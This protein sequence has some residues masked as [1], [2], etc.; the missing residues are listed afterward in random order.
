MKRLVWSALFIALVAL[1]IPTPAFAQV[2]P[3]SSCSALGKTQTANGYKYTWIKAPR[4]FSNPLGKKLIWNKGVQLPK[5]KSLEEAQNTKDILTAL[6]ALGFGV[7]SEEPVQ[8]FN[9]KKFVSSW[10]C[11]IYMAK[12]LST[13]VDIYNNKVNFNFYGGYWIGI[14]KQK[15]V[16]NQ[17]DR[18][19]Y[20]CVRYFAL[21]YGGR[22]YNANT[23]TFEN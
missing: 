15:W 5:P 17:A 8:G 19:D 21:K 20:S 11:A 1:A 23:Q 7:W 14:E 6:N 22:I 9:A 16:V 13:A 18:Y 2:V 3:G 4:S 12:D 10:P